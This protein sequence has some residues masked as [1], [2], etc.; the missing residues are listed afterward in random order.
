MMAGVMQLQ[1]QLLKVL[2]RPATGYASCLVWPS[3]A[4]RFG[5]SWIRLSQQSIFLHMYL[6]SHMSAL[7]QSEQGICK[8]DCAVIET[9]HHLILTT[10]LA[11]DHSGKLLCWSLLSQAMPFGLGLSCA[12]LNCPD[13][14]R[15][16]LVSLG[17]IR[18]G[19]MARLDIFERLNRSGRLDRSDQIR[20]SGQIGQID[21]SMRQA[22]RKVDTQMDRQIDR[23]IDGQTSMDLQDD[24]WI[25]RQT[26]RQADR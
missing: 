8:R 24:R 10:V 21:G 14:I 12:S 4:G 25:I 23:Q 2:G 1:D 16:D 9:V 26:D 6:M 19:W 18:L 22:G 11:Q 20:Q 5:V 3:C 13:Y 15:L 7:S 17:C